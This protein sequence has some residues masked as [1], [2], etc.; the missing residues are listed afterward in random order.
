MKETRYVK[1]AKSLFHT[2]VH[3]RIPLYLHRKSNHV[4]TVWQHITLLVIRQYENKSYR[5]FTDW[6]EETYYLQ[7]FL[8]LSRISHYTTL[9][10]KFTERIQNSLLEKVLQSFIVLS[11]IIH[12]F[13]GID[14]TGFKI[15]TCVLNTIVK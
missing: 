2:L 9:Q 13:V 15:T 11:D 5:R 10:Q 3:S 4:F 7:M 6:L 1:L 12:A 8:Q 14:A